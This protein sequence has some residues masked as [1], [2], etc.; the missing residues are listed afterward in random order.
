MSAEHVFLNGLQL[1]TES[2]GQTISGLTAASF[3]FEKALDMI[4]FLKP[5]ALT[6]DSGKPIRT[7][8][9]ALT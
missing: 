8:Y 4:L 6:P 1:A 7:E 2:A 9:T 5:G 3:K